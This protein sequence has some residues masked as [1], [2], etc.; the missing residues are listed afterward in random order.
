MGKGAEGRSNSRLPESLQWLWRGT[1]SK[2]SLR[3]AWSTYIENQNMKVRIKFRKYGL[4]KYI[5]HLDL[6]RYF[7]KAIRRAGI[8]IR[9]TEGFHPHMIMSFA[10]PL[11]VGMQSEGEYFDIEVNSLPPKEDVVV[12]LNEQMAEGID[13]TS[14]V[15]LKEKA[16]KSMSLVEF[17]R[18]RY[19][20]KED[21]KAHPS[22]ETLNEAIK[23]FYAEAESIIVTKKTK[24]SERQLDLK[25]LIYDFCIINEDGQYGFEFL[26]SAGSTD[27]IKPELV[28]TAF[29]SYLG[30]S[31]DPLDFDRWRIDVYAKGEDGSPVELNRITN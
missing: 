12:K 4:M 16:R 25:P 26:L 1:F 21:A 30:L 29:Y 27:N 8:D 14:C 17:A 10:S 2:R 5:G 22:I 18:Y 11:G 19:L 23:R 31:F 13:V 3:R 6:M 24:K 15:I 9:Y 20:Y 7:Q 28:L